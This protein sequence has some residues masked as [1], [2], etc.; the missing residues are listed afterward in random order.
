[1]AQSLVVAPDDSVAAVS[2]SW[3]WFVGRSRV[4]S[5]AP[6]AVGGSFWSSVDGAGPAA[7][8][9]LLLERVRSGFTV[10]VDVWAAEAER[11][12]KVE[13]TA[14]P[15]AAGG[16]QIELR[17]LF[18]RR[19]RLALFDCEVPR[20]GDAVDVCSF[21]HAVLAFGWTD[22]ERGLR[23]LGFPLEGPQPRLVARVCDEC[24]RAISSGC[25][26]LGLRAA[27][28]AG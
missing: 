6:A 21:C 15:G 8:Y 9:E 22:A 16:V 10:S 25:G 7:M 12:A 24:E 3:N 5:F 28:T 19:R 1:V 4:G 26:A 17:E 20:T 14:V 23:L 11:A 18:E 27:L 13:L 2:E